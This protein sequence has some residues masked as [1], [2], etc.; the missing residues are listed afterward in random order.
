MTEFEIG[1]NG[2]NP[3]IVPINH[4]NSS[5]TNSASRVGQAF[6]VNKIPQD[7]FADKMRPK[8]TRNSNNLAI[9]QSSRNKSQRDNTAGDRR[10]SRK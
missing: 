6:R 9:R 10:K 4:K 8:T 7:Q 3:M 1:L 5:A 2:N